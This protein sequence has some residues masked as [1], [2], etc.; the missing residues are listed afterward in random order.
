[1]PAPTVPSTG[2]DI[3][4]SAA[5]ADTQRTALKP[6][7]VA[8]G[9]LLYALM[10]FRNATVTPGAP[11][12]WTL[13]T[14]VIAPHQGFAAFTHPVPVAAAE[15]A[16]SYQFTANASGRCGLIVGRVL[17][18]DLTTPVDAVGA[19]V[20]T[21]IGSNLGVLVPSVLTLTS[22]TLLL[23]AVANNVASATPIPIS[24][25]P[26]DVEVAEL[27]IPTSSS[28]TLELGAEAVVVAGATGTRSPFWLTPSS[29]VVAVALA[30]RAAAGP[31]TI[32]G[33][34]AGATSG[35]SGNSTRDA[36]AG[37]PS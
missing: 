14:P 12:G 9:D 31:P 3:T 37:G 19:G 13:A 16:V 10:Y 4:T 7:N 35:A 21:A 5:A 23:V 33:R 2:N 18:A 28:S 30:L 6:V 34:L 15:V 25:D 11:A 22:T 27:P 29:S 1:M 20:N 24:P 17:G 32:P 36:R 26:L 8:D